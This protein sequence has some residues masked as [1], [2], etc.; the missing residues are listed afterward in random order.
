[1]GSGP[2]S[3]PVQEQ[4]SLYGHCFLS[5]LLP[6][7]FTEI[8]RWKCEWGPGFLPG[9]SVPAMKNTGGSLDHK[10]VQ[11]LSDPPGLA[12]TPDGGQ[13]G[14]SWWTELE[15]PC[16]SQILLQ[17]WPRVH[18]QQAAQGEN[19]ESPLS[20]AQWRSSHLAPPQSASCQREVH[21]RVSDVRISLASRAFPS[22]PSPSTHT[23]ARTHTDT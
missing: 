15:A 16:A 2:Y 7:P 9:K 4:R 22:V 8:K 5:V 20:A 18:S 13:R 6:L 3:G 10:C 12:P 21:S 17:A 1:M 14:S 19:S 23:H 11:N